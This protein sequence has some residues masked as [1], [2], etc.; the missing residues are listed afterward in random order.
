MSTILR[1]FIHEYDDHGRRT[2]KAEKV[3][4]MLCT[5]AKP[6]VLEIF[7]PDKRATRMRSVRITRAELER[8]LSS[9]NRAE[10]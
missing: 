7:L 6:E 10:K 1:A 8:V 3:F 9:N 5:K 4:A 2:K